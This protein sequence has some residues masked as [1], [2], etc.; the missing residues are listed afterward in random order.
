MNTHLIGVAFDLDGVLIDSTPCHEAAFLQVLEPLGISGFDYRHYAGCRTSDVIRTELARAG[1]DSGPVR[2]AELTAEKQSS[3][4]ER[5]AASQPWHPESLTLLRHLADRYVLALVSSGSRA[6]VEAFLNQSGTRP[7]FRATLSGDDVSQAK[8]DP[9]IYQA[10]FASLGVASGHWMVVEDAPA[11]I[12]SARAAGAGVVGITGTHPA[13]ELTAAGAGAVID[14]LE[15][16]PAVLEEASPGAKVNPADWTV[17]I[18]AAGRGTR[19]GF[20][21]PKLLFQIAG[22]T[23]LEWLLRLFVPLAGRVVVV[24]ST[25]GQE[26]VRQELE[27]LIPGRYRVAV[28]QEPTGMGDAVAC[29][30][31]FV[32]TPFAAIVWGDQ[33]ALRSTSVEACLRL[34]QGP[35]QPDAVC[36]TVIRANPYIHFERDL[37]GK[38]SGLLQ[39][40]EGDAMPGQGES[41]TGF[42]CFRTGVLRELLES[43]ANGRGAR[44]G[45]NNF[46]PVIV[47]AAKTR[48]VLTPHLMT[49][50]ETVGVNSPADAAYLENILKRRLDEHR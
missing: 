24:A 22:R 9:E 46:L 44:T 31:P 10:A 32:A 40:R 11:G 26:A 6:S 12:R 43:T 2:V 45:E 27:R 5:I 48:T 20:D 18:P 50:E 36:P 49:L 38:L 28:Q 4:R 35:S 29:A 42:F 16:L 34:Q 41:D 7:L 30:L 3:A 17:I 15:E 8:P 1:L 37:N 19:L 33:A 47:T 23:M 13:S 39:A 21:K 25:E 14:T